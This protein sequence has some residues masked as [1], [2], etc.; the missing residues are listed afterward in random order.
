MEKILLVED[1]DQYRKLIREVLELNNYEVV[2]VDNPIKGLENIAKTEFD[3]VL[4]DLRLPMLNGIQL[5]ES[6]KRI[7]NNIPIIILTADPD[8]VTQKASLDHNVDAYLSKDKSTSLILKYVEHTIKKAKMNEH[9]QKILVSNAE[10]VELFTDEHIV[11]KRGKMVDLT[12]KELNILKLLLQ[13]KN[14]VI[15]REEFLEKVWHDEKDLLD[16][17]LIDTHIK[18]LRS[19]LKSFSISTVRGI[20]YRWNEIDEI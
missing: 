17:R 14:V 7:N 4:M 19:K 13:N 12:N 6:V 16:A 3:L 11:L 5:A 15:S 9:T 10:G 18:N 20:G 1:N 8:E 2:D